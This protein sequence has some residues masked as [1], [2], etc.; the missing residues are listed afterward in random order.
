MT[1]MA[2]ATRRRRIAATLYDKGCSYRE[3]ADLLGVTYQVARSLVQP[4]RQNARISLNKA[5][6]DGHI[7]KASAC[8]S[9]GRDD[10]RVVGHHDDYNEPF[11]VRWLC[12]KCHH[13][14]HPH[15]PTTRNR[16]HRLFEPQAV[17]A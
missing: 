14:T 10:V 12:D 11:K 7:G 17:P 13:A 2:E 5:I 3:I 16:Q 1:T 9:C 15:E 8:E 6:A 4:E